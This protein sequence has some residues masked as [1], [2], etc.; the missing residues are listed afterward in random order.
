MQVTM[1][2]MPPLRQRRAKQAA[3]DLS[4]LSSWPQRTSEYPRGHNT[5][6][7]GRLACLCV[8]ASLSGRFWWTRV[9]GAGRKLRL[10]RKVERQAYCPRDAT[11]QLGEALWRRLQPIVGLHEVLLVEWLVAGEASPEIGLAVGCLVGTEGLIFPLA[12]TLAVRIFGTPAGPLLHHGVADDVGLDEAAVGILLRVALGVELGGVLHE[13]EHGA[14]RQR[15]PL[16]GGIDRGATGVELAILFDV[17]PIE[18]RIQ[19]ALGIGFRKS[20]L[21]ATGANRTR[22]RKHCRGSSQSRYDNMSA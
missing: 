6:V 8:C 10:D 5:H 22:D 7:C 3:N 18:I 16:L 19:N 1:Q 20:H 12:V 14:V 13:R 2:V 11:V 4:C 15:L 17:G 21:V 9:Q